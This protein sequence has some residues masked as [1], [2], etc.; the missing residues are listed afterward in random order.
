[1]RKGVHF[2]CVR[3]QENGEDK[4]DLIRIGH[5][6]IRVSNI[7]YGDYRAQVG[8]CRTGERRLKEL[9]EAIRARDRSRPSSRPGWI[10][11]SGA[12]SPRS[13]SCRPAPSATRCATIRCRAWP[14]TACRSRAKVKI[15]PKAGL[16]TVDVRDNPDCVPG[17]LNVTEAC[18]IASC[19]T[20]VY[21]NI[22]AID[23]AQSRQRQPHRAAAARQLRGRTAAASDRHLLRHQQRQR[24]AGQRGAM[25][26]LQ[27]GRALWHGGRRRQFLGRARRRLRHRQ[28]AQDRESTT[29]R[30]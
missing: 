10:T 1:M 21:Y 22:D 30:S 13:A 26:L 23:P 24:A 15:D 20:G 2:P 8:A 5:Q 11:A 28:T 18:V 27:D 14:T 19:R 16:I 25:L 4:A 29:S 17:G 12:P 3:I 9:V 7:W 6:K